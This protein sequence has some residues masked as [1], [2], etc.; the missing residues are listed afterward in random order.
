MAKIDTLFMSKTAEKPYPLGLHIPIEPILG[1][2]PPP[3]GL[4][5]GGI[6]K[7]W[8]GVFV[9]TESVL[10]T[11]VGTCHISDQ[12]ILKQKFKMIGDCSVF[13]FLWVVWTENI[14]CVCRV[15]KGP[16]IQNILFL[17]L[18]AHK[19]NSDS[20]TGQCKVHTE[21]CGN[22]QNGK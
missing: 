22:Q 8:L 9:L 18:G 1:S 19:G 10:I 2:T 3:P 12:V 14:W 21:T 13:K 16:K 15:W 20:N 5:H 17:F 6:W 7:H 4:Q 11:E